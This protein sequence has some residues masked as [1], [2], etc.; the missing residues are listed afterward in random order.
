MIREQ[1][2]KGVLNHITKFNDGCFVGQFRSIKVS[3]S[4]LPYKKCINEMM[5]V[6]WDL[7]LVVIKFMMP[8][9]YVT[10]HHLRSFCL[11]LIRIHDL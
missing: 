11:V 8:I 10:F 7:G 3:G 1:T 9:F 6:V 5:S 4:V 2:L